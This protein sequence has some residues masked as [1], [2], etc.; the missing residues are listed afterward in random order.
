MEWQ[1]TTAPR[2]LIAYCTIDGFI[3]A[4]VISGLHVVIDLISGTPAG[5]FFGVVGTSLVLQT[6]LLL[7]TIDL[8]CVY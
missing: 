7:D 6:Q 8:L 4:W 3:S 2:L 1:M 5:T